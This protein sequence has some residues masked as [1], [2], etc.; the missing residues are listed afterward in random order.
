MYFSALIGNPT[1]HSVSHVL[2]EELLKAACIEKVYKHIKIDVATDRLGAAIS[3]LHEL[4]FCG[5]SV[6]HP[7]KLNVMQYLNVIDETAM[8]I[9]AVNTIKPETL[10]GYNTDWV[11]IVKPLKKLMGTD[12][13]AGE[14]TIFGTGGA[15]RAAIYAAKQLKSSKINVVYREDADDSKTED[16]IQN[17]KAVGIEL[18]PY[19][20]M[21][22]LVQRSKL[23]FN[24]TSAGMIGKEDTPF[25]LDDL[26]ELNLNDK[27]YFDAVFNPIATP[28][29]TYFNEHGARTIDGLW[30]MIY[31]GIEALA[32]WLDMKVTVTDAQLKAIHETL[33]KELSH[34]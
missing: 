26:A 28:L 34:V 20:T 18:Y 8:G 13:L 15:A 4:K 11:G 6:T 24:A 14:T 29:L 7:H 31:Q 22:V 33:I 3:A 21:P 9:G 2:Y 30:M 27:V 19:D 10:K 23:I 5:I 25:D 32:I 17:S 1:E 16:L 12:A